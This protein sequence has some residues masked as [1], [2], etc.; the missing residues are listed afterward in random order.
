MADR[1]D[2][3]LLPGLFGISTES[4]ILFSILLE[5]AEKSESVGNHETKFGRSENTH[6]PHTRARSVGR[7][8]LR[9]RLPA[10][11]PNSDLSLARGVTLPTNE[12]LIALVRRIVAIPKPR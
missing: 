8:I 7:R 1:R 6:A 12:P 3:N 4:R 5:G 10:C 11:K 2:F 9:Y